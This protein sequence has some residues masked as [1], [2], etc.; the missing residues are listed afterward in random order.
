M[1]QH[2]R[3]FMDEPDIGSGEKS[4][5]QEDVDN[6]VRSVDGSLIGQPLDG[7]QHHQV[8]DEQRYANLPP[9]RS[10]E[11]GATAQH[12]GRYLR[13]GTHLAR[14]V[15]QKMDDGTYEA[16]VY[17]RL[18]REPEIAETYIPAGTFRSEQEAWRAAEERARRT[19]IEHEF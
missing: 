13:D 18:V 15:A 19:L 2:G 17:V 6:D 7:R 9:G 5:G 10:G 1:G 14:I 12:T 3:H 16:Q 11:R 8:V 4:P